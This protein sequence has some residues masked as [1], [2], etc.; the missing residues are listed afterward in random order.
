METK[1]LQMLHL[2]NGDFVTTLSGKFQNRKRYSAPSRLTVRAVIPGTIL[3]IF[4]TKGQVV[5]E[6]DSLCVM[7]SMKM[8]NTV[9]A[10][11]G[12]RVSEVCVTVGVP[13]GKGQIMFVFE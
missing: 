10:P 5:S 6:G 11:A 2:E 13:V 3:E 12:G 1:D 7:D 4:V 9:C 8:N